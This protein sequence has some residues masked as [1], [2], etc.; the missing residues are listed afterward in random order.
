MTA[1]PAAVAEIVELL[2][3]LPGANAVVLGG[4]HVEA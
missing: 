3:H 4:S 2:A 1:L